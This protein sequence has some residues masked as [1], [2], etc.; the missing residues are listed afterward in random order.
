[1]RAPLFVVVLALAWFTASNL[2][3]SCVA[4][5]LARLM[6]RRPIAG[7]P[8]SVARAL[9]AL[10]V[11]PAAVSIFFTLAVFLPAQWQWEPARVNESAGYSIV[12]L[13]AGGAALLLITFRRALR[14]TLATLAVVKH[15]QRAAREDTRRTASD[16]P[17]LVVPDRSP[18]MSLAGVLRPRVFVAKD[19]RA[20]L[21]AEEL[22]VSLAHEAAHARAADNLK[23]LI[24]AWCPGLLSVGPLGR[25][26]DARWEA[27]TE[28]AADADA[29]GGSGRRAIALAS[30]LVKVARLTPVGG[31]A[32]S[33]ASRVHHQALLAARIERLLQ[34]GD[35]VMPPRRLPR[36][37]VIVAAV[38]LILAG[39]LATCNPWLAVHQA[40]EGLIRVLP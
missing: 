29:V 30:A 27:A 33:L 28:F 18:G 12:A 15:W 1:M 13:A 5:L 14:D 40:T 26:L 21:T 38:G 37:T 17:V 32:P 34:S 6:Q 9:F 22:D 2:L 35:H 16:L 11:G 20:E 39:V 31:A 23:R 24:A 25:G 19:V 4:A 36:P 7:R 8:T 10:I 3:F